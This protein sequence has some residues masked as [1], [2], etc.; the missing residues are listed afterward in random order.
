MH[1]LSLLRPAALILACSLPLASAFAAAPSQFKATP[2]HEPQAG[3]PTGTVTQMPEWRSTVLPGT[4]RD[5][6]I[7]VPAQYKPDGT[8]A[9]MVFQDGRNYINLKG[10]W[11]V[12][13]VFDNLIAQ[14][15]R[16]HV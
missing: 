11:R 3:V 7:Y 13:T 14:I 10:D 15:G 8:A 12:P 2:D 6:W 16:A 5:W 1:C 9:V 4:T